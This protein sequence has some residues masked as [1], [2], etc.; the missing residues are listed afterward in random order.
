MGIKQFAWFL[1][2][3]LFIANAA[4]AQRSKDEQNLH[5]F[6]APNLGFRL[7]TGFSVPERYSANKTVFRD[8]LNKADRPGQNMNFGVAYIRKKN[9]LEAV[10]IGIGYT[11]VGFRRVIDGVKIGT[12]IHPKIGVVPNLAGSGNMQINQD[13]RYHYLEFSYLK[14][15]SA[16]GYSRNLK[17]FDLWWTYGLSA[18]ALLRDRVMVET[19]G[20]SHS[21][22]ESRIA[23]QDDNLKGFPV[24]MWLN[25]GY[26]A[27]YTMF[28]KTN[29]FVHGRLRLPLLPSATG[30]QTIFLPQLGIEAGLIF[31]LNEEK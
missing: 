16:E 4:K 26:K 5:V 3:L 7:M 24:N 13:F 14:T 30:V 8:S 28:K 6:I 9:A 11:T 18:G 10:S 20:F 27:D 12:D 22:G 15:K 29:A 21:N 25:V 2:G 31:K 19:I 23:V 1:G 17:E